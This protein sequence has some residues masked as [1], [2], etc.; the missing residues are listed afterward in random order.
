MPYNRFYLIFKIVPGE[1]EGNEIGFQGGSVLD[2]IRWSYEL[3][4]GSLGNIGRLYPNVAN[5]GGLQSPGVKGEVV[6]FYLEL[7]TT[8]N[9]KFSGVPEG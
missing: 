1:R 8:Q 4:P 2:E 3:I 9:L 5:A 6:V 7:L